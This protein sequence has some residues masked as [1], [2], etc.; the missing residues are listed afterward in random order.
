MSRRL[1]GERVVVKIQGCPTRDGVLISGVKKPTKVIQ[2]F[3]VRFPNGDVRIYRGDQLLLRGT[4][5]PLL[6]YIR[7]G[8]IIFTK[9]TLGVVRF[10]GL[11]E[12][13]IGTVIVIEPIDPKLPT[14]PSVASFRKTFPSA[15]LADSR[16]YNIVRG[17]DEILKVLPPD[18]LL[19]QLSKIKDKYLAYVED[20]RN[21]DQIF[22]EDINKRS[23]RITELENEIRE[24]EKEMKPPVIDG[25]REAV[26]AEDD[27]VNLTRIVFQ[28]GRLGIKAIWSTGE[29]EGVSPDMQAESLGVQVGWTIV[30]IDDVDYSEETLDTK[31]AGRVDY[32]LTFKIPIRSDERTP[33]IEDERTVKPN[34]A[35]DTDAKSALYSE[36]EREKYE[37]QIQELNDHIEDFQYT[38]EALQNKN[39]KMEEEHKELPKLRHKVEQLRNSKTMFIGQI[40]EVQKREKEWKQKAEENEQKYKKLAMELQ[41]ADKPESM[42]MEDSSKKEKDIKTVKAKKRGGARHGRKSSVQMPKPDSANTLSIGSQPTPHIGDGASQKVS[43]SSLTNS[44]D[45]NNSSAKNNRNKPKKEPKKKPR[46]PRW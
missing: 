35:G 3:P 39:T 7:V 34:P 42:K 15:N 40:K 5:A 38:I 30:K 31:V 14:D 11:H 10:I 13:Y 6:E 45:G 25:D 27:E 41:A 4:Q 12:D 29:V 32:T 9:K 17:V 23:K 8:D 26:P 28:P 21:S 1:L 20:S 36:T 22:E 44:T 2:K 19:Q 46:F 24:Q 16:A 18:T 43:M 37:R 33:E